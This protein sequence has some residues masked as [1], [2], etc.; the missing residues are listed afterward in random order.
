M[1]AATSWPK[2]I[3]CHKHQVQSWSVSCS[4]YM[5]VKREDN[6]KTSLKSGLKK[7]KQVLNRSCLF[8][9]YAVTVLLATGTRER[10]SL[11]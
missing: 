1:V 5:K 7:A 9:C 8:S 10:C 4:Q 3:D 11:R 6:N 2:L